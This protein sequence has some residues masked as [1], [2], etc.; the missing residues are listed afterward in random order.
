MTRIPNLHTESQY[1]DWLAELRTE[2]KARNLDIGEAFDA[3]S[4]RTAYDE[5]GLTPRAAV[6]D[7]AAW[8]FA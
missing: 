8:W 5:Y 2:L 1:D 3:Y 4:F 7:Y 6:E